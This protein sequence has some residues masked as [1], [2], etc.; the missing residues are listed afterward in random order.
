VKKTDKQME[1]A[2]VAVLTEVCDAALQQVPG[3][4]WITHFVNYKHFPASLIVVSVFDTDD[5]LAA[6]RAQHHDRWL[7]QVIQDKLATIKVPIN[8][9]RQQIRFDTEQACQRNN[10]GNWQERYQ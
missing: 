3:F 4:Q 10:N 9:R 1:R 8:P 7:Q 2:L 5:Q 6:A